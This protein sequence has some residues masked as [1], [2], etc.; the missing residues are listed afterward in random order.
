[1]PQEG[2]AKSVHYSLDFFLHL[3]SMTLK[4]SF[5]THTFCKICLSVWLH[6]VLALGPKPQA[7]HL[8][9]SG[10]PTLPLH[11]HKLLCPQARDISSRNMWHISVTST[12]TQP[13]NCPT[14]HTLP[15]SHTHRAQSGRSQQIEKPQRWCY[16]GWGTPVFA[17]HGPAPHSTHCL[18]KLLKNSSGLLCLCLLFQLTAQPAC[19]IHSLP[20]SE[21]SYILLFLLEVNW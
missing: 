21:R 9:D 6:F 17:G 19:F 7:Y 5:L 15:A 10:N 14:L 8:T 4:A 3:F 18:S 1:M 13:L 20:S 11:K 12:R 16:K 2:K